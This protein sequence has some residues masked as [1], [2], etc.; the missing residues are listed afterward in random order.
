M[1]RRDS[2]DVSDLARQSSI[3]LRV[4][5]PVVFISCKFFLPVNVVSP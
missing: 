3:G 2:R 1:I 4:V 5:S